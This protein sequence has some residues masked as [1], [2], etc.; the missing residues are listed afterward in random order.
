MS[1]ANGDPGRHTASYLISTVD[2]PSS[3]TRCGAFGDDSFDNG[4]IAEP[5]PRLAHCSSTR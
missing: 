1:A 5:N 4:K 2:R 3:N